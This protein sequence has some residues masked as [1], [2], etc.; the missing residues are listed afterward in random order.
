M[1]PFKINLANLNNP[2]HC[3]SEKKVKVQ[4]NGKNEDSKRNLVLNLK[5][6]LGHDSESFECNCQ[7]RACLCGKICMIYNKI[8]FYV[9]GQALI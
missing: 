9:I 1:Y 3:F 5:K 8:A 4:Y 2:N 7:L 6:I